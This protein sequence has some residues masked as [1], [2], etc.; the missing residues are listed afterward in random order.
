M[1]SV[2]DNDGVVIGRVQAQVVGWLDAHE[3]DFLDS[4]GMPDAL[5]RVRYLTGRLAGDEEDLQESELLESV[6]PRRVCQVVVK[7]DV[8]AS[9]ALDGVLEQLRSVRFGRKSIRTVSG[10]SSGL[11]KCLGFGLVN[12]RR[13]GM[14]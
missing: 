11:P 12:T 14:G 13:S 4:L 8:E 10:T 1:R 6:P 5:Y 9:P 2:F 3:S 7:A